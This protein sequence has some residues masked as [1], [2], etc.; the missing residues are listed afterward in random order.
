MR[1]Y[2]P[3]LLCEVYFVT[4]ASSKFTNA[5]V[6]ITNST[7]IE[8]T[9]RVNNSFSQFPDPTTQS[10]ASKGSGSSI[11][12]A[13]YII[14]GLGGTSESAE[15]ETSTAS[16]VTR[17]ITTA[18]SADSDPSSTSSIS[19]Q[20]SR[21]ASDLLS[22]ATENGTNVSGHAP[23]QATNFS[24]AASTISANG[25]ITE[26]TPYTSLTAHAH[27]MNGSLAPPYTTWQSFTY[28]TSCLWNDSSCYSVCRDYVSSCEAEWAAY[29]SGAVS[30]STSYSISTVYVS[31]PMAKAKLRPLLTSLYSIPA[32]Q[33]SASSRLLPH[34][35]LCYR[36][37][38]VPILN[39]A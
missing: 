18:S 2:T 30:T 33:L 26:S 10:P 4:F 14:N 20:I 9:S 15:G 6:A 19:S 5:T 22:Y 32:P 1:T 11:G 12:L 31:E 3:L 7:L 24:T 21:Q 23:S 17:T 29:A 8:P 34:I 16:P 35:L 27:A 39:P 28:A 36:G 38:K 13:E 37:A 25:T